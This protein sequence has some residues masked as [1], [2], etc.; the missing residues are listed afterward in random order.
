M[1]VCIT[2]KTQLYTCTCS[3]QV[4]VRV[5]EKTADFLVIGDEEPV[6]HSYRVAWSE[7]LTRGCAQRSQHSFWEHVTGDLYAVHKTL[8]YTQNVTG[9]PCAQNTTPWSTYDCIGVVLICPGRG[10]NAYSFCARTCLG[11]FLRARLKCAHV[12]LRRRVL[13]MRSVHFCLGM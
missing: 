9:D 7:R 3:C 11:Y 1:Y 13:V 10:E 4:G 5:G 12:E 8:L 2:H 6:L